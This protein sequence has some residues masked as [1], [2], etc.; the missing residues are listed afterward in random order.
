MDRLFSLFRI[1]V[2]CLNLTKSYVSDTMFRGEIPNWKFISVLTMETRV[3]TVKCVSFSSVTG[4]FLGVSSYRRRRILS[5]LASFH[6]RYTNVHVVLC[7]ELE[8]SGISRREKFYLI[9]S[10]DL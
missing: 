8:T 4:C 3:A 6:Q 10:N 7:L 5:C 9:K 2:E 1:Q